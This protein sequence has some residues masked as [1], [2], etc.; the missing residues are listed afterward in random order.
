M[1]ILAHLTG[2]CLAP[3]VRGLPDDRGA[4]TSNTPA[5]Y[6]V[7]RI[8][9]SPLFFFDATG[10]FH[11]LLIA[12]RIRISPL[13]RGC[14]IL[15]YKQR[16]NLLFRSI[17]FHLQDFLALSPAKIFYRHNY[18][19]GR[20]TVRRYN[21]RFSKFFYNAAKGLIQEIRFVLVYNKPIYL[22]GTYPP[23]YLPVII[24]N[25]RTACGARKINRQTDNV[26]KRPRSFFR[27][28]Y[29]EIKFMLLPP[30]VRKAP[31]IYFAFR[32]R[33]H[34]HLVMIYPKCL[35]QAI[36]PRGLAGVVVKDLQ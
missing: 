24:N 31:P 6:T 27:R 32:K 18:I 17:A 19:I 20:R 15:A 34:F 25:L 11:D 33:L 22:E 1:K 30:L 26:N 29:L 28:F 4:T 5:A 16:M 14:K 13:R 21:R 35:I 12:S 3:I 36:L 8:D 10:C 9:N 2:R 23:A 7:L